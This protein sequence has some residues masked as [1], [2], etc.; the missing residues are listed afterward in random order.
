MEDVLGMGLPDF[1][2]DLG[3]AYEVGEPDGRSRHF[4]V[5]EKLMPRDSGGR[6]RSFNVGR[7]TSCLMQCPANEDV[8]NVAETTVSS[9]GLPDGCNW[10]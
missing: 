4:C 1:G 6:D 9:P 2:I 7:D 8:V 3:I 10:S 5:V